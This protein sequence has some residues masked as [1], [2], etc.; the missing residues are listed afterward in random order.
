MK[1]FGVVIGD[2]GFLTSYDYPKPGV[3]V[4]HGAVHA[5]RANFDHVVPAWRGGKTDQAN[6][7]SS[8]WFCNFGKRRW[9]IEQ[10]G[11]ADP[12]DRAPIPIDSW[13]GLN[14]FSTALA[15]AAQSIRDANAGLE[16]AQHPRGK[17]ART[18]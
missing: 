1:D 6:L 17:A 15:K 5:F 18:N 4:R 8:C 11:L 7:V 13:T 3:I 10:L 9:T 14:E 2:N 16:A 12:R